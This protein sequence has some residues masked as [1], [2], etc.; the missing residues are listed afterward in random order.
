MNKK[1]I[2]L[3]FAAMALVGLDAVAMVLFLAHK[4]ILTTVICIVLVF[5]SCILFMKTNEKIRLPEGYTAVQALFFY[6][7]CV[8]AGVDNKKHAMKK[9]YLLREFAEKTDYA[10]NFDDNALISLYSQGKEVSDILKDKKKG[11]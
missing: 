1:D 10:K 5:A 6:R 8:K 9:I 3:W 11:K 7:K 4:S 2:R